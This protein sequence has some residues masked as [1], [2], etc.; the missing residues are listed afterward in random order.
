[1]KTKDLNNTCIKYNGREEAL[2]I[3]KV[4]E[5]N[6]PTIVWCDNAPVVD[7]E[8][9]GY[10]D[11]NY[12]TITMEGVEEPMILHLSGERGKR[13]EITIRDLISNKYEKL[14]EKYKL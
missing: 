10:K 4:I 8:Y 2:K 12:I 13:K 7:I 6:H 11:W 3:L 5:E 1:M 9:Q 14:L